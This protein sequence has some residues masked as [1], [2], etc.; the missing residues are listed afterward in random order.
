MHWGYHGPQI[1]WDSMQL[2]I[3]GGALSTRGWCVREPKASLT[4]TSFALPVIQTADT[5]C[6]G[7]GPP[8]V[9]G[10]EPTV[11]GGVPKST[12]Y[13]TMAQARP[14][15]AV[16]TATRAMSIKRRIP[17]A[18][19]DGFEF[20]LFIKISSFSKNK[21]HPSTRVRASLGDAKVD[22]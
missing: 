14:E 12:S 8:P 4:K 7:A 21:T 19:T 1:H 2:G 5:V 10:G 17:F 18:R 9:T 3:T 6:R 15:I 16:M 11:F 22:C 20:L 13:S